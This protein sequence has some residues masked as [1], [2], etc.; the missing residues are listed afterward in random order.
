MSLKLGGGGSGRVGRR[1]GVLGRRRF[2]QGHRAH[3]CGGRALLSARIRR[4][5]RGGTISPPTTAADYRL[6]GSA[7]FKGFILPRGENQVKHFNENVPRETSVVRRI[8]GSDSVRVRPTR[9]R[10]MVHPFLPWPTRPLPFRPFGQNPQAHRSPCRWSALLGP[11][12]SAAG[13]FGLPRALRT[14]GPLSW[15]V[16]RLPSRSE[17]SGDD[18]GPALGIWGGTATTIP[19]AWFVSET[20]ST[21]NTWQ[22]SGLLGSQSER[23]ADRLCL[24]GETSPLWAVR[25][26]T[27]VDADHV[28]RGTLRRPSSNTTGPG[29]DSTPTG[30]RVFRPL[31]PTLPTRSRK[32]TA[33]ATFGLGR[34][35]C[36][37]ATQFQKSGRFEWDAHPP[38]KAVGGTRRLDQYLIAEPTVDSGTDAQG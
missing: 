3:T 16:H 2:D 11:C 35:V 32:D 37:I 27:K 25:S 38:R 7:S 12:A 30:L 20:C 33:L 36:R 23:A 9:G 10:R 17:D 21:W 14:A 15:I 5:L 6:L 26:G 18:Q 22:S 4:I 24:T 29:W 31:H 1:S 19:G 34:C 13:R 8:L 28:P